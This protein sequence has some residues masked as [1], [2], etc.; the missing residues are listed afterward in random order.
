MIIVTGANGQLGRQVIDKLL[1]HVPAEQIGASVRDT[2]SV[3]ELA[4]RGVRVRHGDFADPSTLAHSFEGASKVLVVSASTPGVPSAPMNIA[5][6]DA[7]TEAG[8]RRVFYTSH[9]GQRSESKFPPMPAHHQVEAHGRSLAVPFTALRN[10]F[11]A[12]LAPNLL[13][14]AIETGELKAPADGPMSWTAHPDLAEAIATILTSDDINDDAIDL[15]ASEAVNLD[16]IAAIVSKITGKTITRVVVDDETMRA[17]LSERGLPDGM[18]G[19]SLGIYGAASDGHFALVDPTLERL[20]GRRP[21][22]IEEMLHA[23][24]A[25]S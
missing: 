1:D 8:A 18:I 21:T 19:F 6:L 24:L 9:V 23:S 12:E 13:G 2:D 20:I 14:D 15:T 17:Q 22:S 25:K 5:A 3:R 10:G 16:D 4:D 7:A 11:Y